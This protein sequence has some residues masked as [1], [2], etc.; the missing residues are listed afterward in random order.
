M[1]KT[2][3]TWY[4][5]WRSMIRRCQSSKADNFKRYG[6]IGITVCEEWKDFEKFSEWASNNGWFE[7][8]TIDRI[9]NNKG[10]YPENCRWATKK[11]QA[12][13]RRTTRYITHNGETHCISEWC[14][15]L[16]VNKTL[17][18]NRLNRGWNEEQI[19]ERVYTSPHER[20]M[21]NCQT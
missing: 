21:C 17:L 9:D 14:E 3:Q 10:Y 2:K 11:E 1:L 4:N 19:F 13:N 7:G 16:G 5:S 15:I 12:H 18:Y 8:A 20:R 6:A